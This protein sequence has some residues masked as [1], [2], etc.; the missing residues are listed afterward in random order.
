MNKFKI[1]ILLVSVLAF[2]QCRKYEKTAGVGKASFETKN[3]ETL[4]GIVL[5]ENGS[6][7]QAAVVTSQSQTYTTAADGFFVFN[8]IDVVNNRYIVKIT[9]TGY[10]SVTRSA[11]IEDD[12]PARVAVRLVPITPGATVDTTS[13]MTSEGGT[14]QVGNLLKFDFPEDVIMYESGLPYEGRVHIAASYTDPTDADYSMEVY[15]GDQ[16]GIDEYNEHLLLRAFVGTNIELHDGNG[17]KLQLNPNMGEDV[18]FEMAIPAG[19]SNLCPDDVDIWTFD[20]DFGVRSTASGGTGSAHKVGGKLRGR[21]GHFSYISCEIGYKSTATIFG[22]VSDTNGNV[23]PGVLVKIGESYAVTD[24]QGN[25]SRNVIAGLPVTVEIYPDYFGITI[26]PKTVTPYGNKTVNFTVPAQRRVTGRLVDCAGQK[27]PGHLSFYLAGGTMGVVSV[28]TTDGNFTVHL[29]FFATDPDIRAYG[30]NMHKEISV[31]LSANPEDI[32][33]IVLCPPPPIGNNFVTINGDSL[34]FYTL[35]GFDNYTGTYY[36]ASGETGIDLSGPNGYIYIY[37]DG[38]TTGTFNII[39]CYAEIP[40]ENWMGNMVSGTVT[41]TRY[42]EVGGLIEG[43]FTG[44]FDDG[45]Q[46]TNAEFSVIRQND[47]GI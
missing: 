31:M 13:F 18:D 2:T 5:D 27:V 39:S 46:I 35:T 32:G 36:S 47:A 14:V 9:K 24:A 29:P 30:N 17:Q 43:T 12:K 20:D 15:G 22:N 38:H 33:D 26:P 6:P 45:S 10:F 40:S 23:V 41:V 11:E 37:F 42:D 28:Y 34:T 19:L 7:V 44:T 4:S 3:L 21:V 16:K 1:I 8:N 25:Y